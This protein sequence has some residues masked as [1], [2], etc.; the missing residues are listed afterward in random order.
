MPVPFD[1]V[2]APTPIRASAHIES[3]SE[4]RRRAAEDGAWWL[5][6]IDAAATAERD[7][8]FGAV[9]ALMVDR[10]RNW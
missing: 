8:G 10:L 4:A 3:R 2:D 1:A 9:Y 7:D 6:V 5:G